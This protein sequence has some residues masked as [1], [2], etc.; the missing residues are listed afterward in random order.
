MEI[1]I[2]GTDTKKIGNNICQ[3]SDD[4]SN[5]INK[6]LNSIESINTA[7]NG[8]DALKYIQIMRDRYIIGLRELNDVI[9][10]YGNYLENVPEAYS[11]LDETF[12]TKSIN[13]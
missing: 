6:L 9:K 2:D 1:I 5:D 12:S 13:V 7:W 10:K 8:A 3:Y 11:S 4:F